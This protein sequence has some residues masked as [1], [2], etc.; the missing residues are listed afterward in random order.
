[1]TSLAHP[2]PRMERAPVRARG[3]QPVDGEPELVGRNGI[4][5]I[6]ILLVQA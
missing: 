2:L 3:E 6:F 5:A 4:T 1:M